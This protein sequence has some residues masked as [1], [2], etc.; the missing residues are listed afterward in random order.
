MIVKAISV[1]GYPVEGNQIEY[2]LDGTWVIDRHPSGYRATKVRE[3]T[4]EKIEEEN[5]AFQG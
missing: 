4:I 3:E 1:L 5:D 2:R